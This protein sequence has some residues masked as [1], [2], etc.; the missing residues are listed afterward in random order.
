[1]IDGL[2][3]EGNDV[4]TPGSIPD[5]FVVADRNSGPQ[6]CRNVT[7]ANN[8]TRSN[9]ILLQGSPASNN[10]IQGN[11]QLGGQGTIRNLAKA[12]VTGNKGYQVK[13]S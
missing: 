13:D 1:M 10:V 8:V 2:L 3:V 7:I 4:S 11:R 6:P 5:I 9:G 12:K